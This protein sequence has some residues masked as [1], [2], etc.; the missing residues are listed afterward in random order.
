MPIPRAV[1]KFNRSV[2]N[3][4]LR[5]LSGIGP[6]VEIEHVGR[7]SGRV[8]RT[9]LLAFREGGVVT[10]ALTYGPDVDWLKNIEAAGGARLHHGRRVL[11]LGPPRG[12]AEEV[13]MARMP[14]VVRA[15]LPLA[16]VRDFIEL[17]VLP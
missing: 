3:P 5:H 11:D 14:L 13:G 6:F 2:V 9:P 4:V 8:R 10:V 17:P 1:T 16:G 12:L 7:R 15:L